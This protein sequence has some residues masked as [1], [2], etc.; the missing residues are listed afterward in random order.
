[1]T[2]KKL[3]ALKDDLARG[4]EVIESLKTQFTKALAAG[5]EDAKEALDV[6]AEFE[7]ENAESADVKVVALH[8]TIVDGVRLTKGQEATVTKRQFGAL[9]HR[10]KK[11]TCI[12]VLFGLLFLGASAKAQYRPITLQGGTNGLAVATG[13]TPF[14]DTL[15]TNLI[16]ATKSRFL[17][18]QISFTNANATAN[19]SNVVFSFAKSV[20]GV[21]F[22]STNT[23]SLINVTVPSR[24]DTAVAQLTT[25][26]TL[27][28]IG[29]LKLCCRSN[30]CTN[31]ITNV[32]IKVVDSQNKP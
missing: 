1:M 18:V 14:V 15:V 30:F 4:A 12:A 8:D 5:D 21:T 19:S 7:K 22:D 25:N 11:V 20:D 6:I 31:V 13:G 29:Y 10:L 3:K 27:D 17:A 23:P 2:A 28:A 32:T 24:T 26:I 16:T 9:A